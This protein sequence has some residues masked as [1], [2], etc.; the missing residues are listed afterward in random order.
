MKRLLLLSVMFCIGVLQGFAQ[1]TSFT[2]TDENGVNW[3]CSLNYGM[4]M[5]DGTY[6][7]TTYVY[8]NGASNYGEEVTVPGVVKYEG[9]DYTV[10]QL[11][12]IFC[13]NQT[14][15]KATLPKS[16]TSLYGTFDGCTLLSEIVNTEQIQSCSYAFNN[17]SS[18]KSIDL[19]NCETIEGGCTFYSCKKL[20]SIKLKKCTTIAPQAFIDCSS[21]QSVGD[22]SSCTTIGK[23]AFRGCSSLRS[24]DISSCTSLGEEAFADCSKLEE[25]KLSKQ[26][27][28]INNGT[29]SRCTK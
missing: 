28:K 20:Q 22:L 19:S 16:V 6:K 1:S 7:D 5:P 4:F 18:L 29:F 11:G 8:V 21:L 15:K 9:K 24:I 10:T 14:L 13:N 3:E 12:N 26:L 17:C 2:Y 23:E 27:N 25:V